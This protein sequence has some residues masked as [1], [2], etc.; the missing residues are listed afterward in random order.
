MKNGKYSK[1]NGAKAGLNKMITLGLVMVLVLGCVVGGTIAWFTDKTEKVVNTFTIGNID[2]TLEESDSKQDADGNANTNSYKMVPG[3]TISKD[4]KATVV[5][6]SEDC[7]LFV[8]VTETGVSFTPAGESAPMVYSF[9]DFL[10]YEIAEGWE[11][12][13]DGIYYKVFDSKDA[14]NTNEMGTA[15]SILK[16]D[17]VKVQNTVTAE[18]MSAMT[19]NNL[20]PKLNFTAYAVQLYKNNTDKFTAAE[21][22]DI[23]STN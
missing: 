15:Y 8:K 11:K 18:M 13:E 4:P 5:N 2:I 16:N 3:W 17:Q 10:T 9:D 14:D 12:L 23:V 20:N 6:G 19:T 21:A 1:N 22:W 7:Y